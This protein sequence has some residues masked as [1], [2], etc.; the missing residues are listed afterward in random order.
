M[1]NDKTKFELW[2][3][4]LSSDDIDLVD[5]LSNM[6]ENEISEE[7]F[8]LIDKNEQKYYPRIEEYI[9]KNINRYVDF[10]I[11]E[12]YALYNQELID[13]NDD[14]SSGLYNCDEIYVRAIANALGFLW[15]V[16]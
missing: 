10:I 4:N 6:C 14:W 1:R 5:K 3:K 9:K 12:T 13:S 15:L 2:C 11:T 8:E 16:N 7:L